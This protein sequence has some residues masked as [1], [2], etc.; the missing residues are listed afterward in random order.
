MENEVYTTLTEREK[1]L[2]ERVYKLERDLLTALTKVAHLEIELASLQKVKL[3][4]MQVHV[5]VAEEKIDAIGE[6]LR[7]LIIDLIQ[8]SKEDYKEE[9]PRKVKIIRRQ[10]SSHR[11]ESVKEQIN[12]PITM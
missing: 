12:D 10:H 5:E 8:T 9:T 4:S 7:D 3:A 2:E 11:E 1:T 6:A